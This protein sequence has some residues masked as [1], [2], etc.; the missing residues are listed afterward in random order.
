M[1]S[2]SILSKLLSLKQPFKKLIL[3]RSRLVLRTCFKSVSCLIG[4]HVIAAGILQTNRTGYTSWSQKHFLCIHINKFIFWWI[5]SWYLFLWLDVGTCLVMNQLRLF[6][7]WLYYCTRQ[8]FHS[9]MMLLN[10]VKF[11]NSFKMSLTK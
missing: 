11:I 3:M 6:L 1:T 4:S 8:I 7:G 10:I 9:W 2:I 5:Q